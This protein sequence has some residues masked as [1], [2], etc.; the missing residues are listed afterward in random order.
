MEFELFCTKKVYSLICRLSRFSWLGRWFLVQTSD[1][2]TDGLAQDIA[3]IRKLLDEND[4]PEIK[5]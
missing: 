3:E 1:E 5:S 4:Q 2:E